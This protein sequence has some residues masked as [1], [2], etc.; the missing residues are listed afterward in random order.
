MTGTIRSARRSGEVGTLEAPSMAIGQVLAMEGEVGRARTDQ[1]EVAFHPAVSCLVRPRPG[2]R[3]L[4]A[5]EPS[6]GGF[7]LAVLERPPGVPGLELVLEGPVDVTVQGE[8]TLKGD[9]IT[10][11]S[12][13]LT[14]LAGTV[15]L[16]AEHGS[17]RVGRWSFLGR[18]LETQVEHLHIFS[19]HL[20]QSCQRLVTRSQESSR[21]VEGHD[22]VQAGSQRTLVQDGLVLQAGDTHL[23]ARKHVSVTAGHIN[24]N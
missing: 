13:A 8:L 4:L 20:E 9:A 19:L 15:R 18:F 1:G 16:Q 10:L 14:G 11:A 21:F 23:M 3:V 2:D 12:G 7:A 24:L 5:L 22:E 17:A 6:G